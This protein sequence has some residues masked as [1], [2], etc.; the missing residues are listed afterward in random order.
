M[1]TLSLSKLLSNAKPSATLA[2]AQS[3]RDLQNRGL[4]IAVMSAGEPDLPTPPYIYEKAIEAIKNGKTHYS[5]VR[6][7]PHMIEAMKEK[8]ARDQK[9]SYETSE[10]M[11]TVGAKSAIMMALKA[12][13]NPR[14]EVII[15][16]PYWVSYYEQVLLAQGI[17]VVVNCQKENEFMPTKKDILQAVTPNT[18]AIIL[19]SPNNPTGAVISKN[20]LIDLADILH[21]TSIWVI[22][23]EI[24]EKLLF[25]N[26]VHYSPASLSSDMKERTIVISGVSKA[27]AMTGWRVGVVAANKEV[28]KAMAVLQG[29]E[30]TCL[31]DF[32]QEAASYALLED[33]K[34]KEFIKE[35]VS[36]YKER[37]DLGLELAS[38]IPHIDIFKPK[39]A[40]YLWIDFS[41]YI[42]KAIKERKIKDD[43]DLSM[44]ILN[45]AHVAL[46]AGTPFGGKNYLR[47]STAS[48]SSDIQKCFSRL[49]NWLK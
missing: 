14:D 31:P 20:C 10:V 44:R 34:V 24:Y 3:A 12:I 26:E 42:G 38:Q 45:E 11:C 25:D 41:Y 18:K 23:D 17:P 2:M 29:Q 1:S 37:R 9:V 22:S 5:P 30:T 21:D 6:G 46:V 8:F 19:N 33:N 49:Q 7:N 27:Y 28:I 4:D 13:V 16:A 32:I 35:A 43:M 48:S 47:L 36:S 39:G 15:F 40:F